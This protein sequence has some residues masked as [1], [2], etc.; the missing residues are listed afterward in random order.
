MGV[1]LSDARPPRSNHSPFPTPTCGPTKTRGGG[2]HIC[3]AH[4]NSDADFRNRSSCSSSS[5]A[6]RGRVGRTN[7][8]RI[9]PT[10]RY[11]ILAAVVIF[12]GTSTSAG[13]DPQCGFAGVD[14]A[15]IFEL[16]TLP[17]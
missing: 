12:T 9:A 6:G 10:A 2:R 15:L 14:I 17:P 3:Q 13:D 8:A 16:A 1:A 7:Y 5:K 11:R 4:A